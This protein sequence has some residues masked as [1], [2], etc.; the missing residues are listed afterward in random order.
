MVVEGLMGLA[1]TLFFVFIS[2]TGVFD[3][4]EALETKA[5]DVRARMAAH[6]DKNTQIELVVIGDEDLSE[7]GPFPWPRDILARGI[8]NL[9]LAGAKVIALNIPFSGPERDPGLTALRRLR[10]RYEVLGL[11]Q[12][13]SGLQFYEELSESERDLDND[14]KL[15]RSLKEAE[16][17]VLPVSFDESGKGSDEVRPDFM[18]AHAFKRIREGNRVG[19]PPI[20]RRFRQVKPI[21]HAFAEAAAGMGYNNLFPGPD[22][23]IRN[24][25]HAV[26]YSGG[27]YYPSFPLAIVKVFKGLRDEDMTLVLGDSIRLR[28]NPSTTLKV[29]LSDPVGTLI[30][31][32]QGPNKVFHYTPFT[33]VFKNQ[34]Q[35]GL[36]RDKIV[37]VG[38][39]AAHLGDRF[40]T[41]VSE[42]LPG[43]EIIANCVADILNED[44]FLRPSWTPLAEVA[45]IIL[46]GFFIT[47][48]LPRLR[49]GVGIGITL[50]LLAGYCVGGGV[51]FSISNIYLRVMPPLF[52]LIVGPM[53]V[54]STRLWMTGREERAQT[55]DGIYRER[56]ESRGWMG[57]AE[58]TVAL[59]PSTGMGPR[60][61]KGP[62]G[63]AAGRAALGR[64]ELLE[65]IGRGTMGVVYKGRDPKIG[66]TVAIK[67]VDLSEFDEEAL[68]E[69]KERFFREA[70]SVGLLSHP[71]IV[72]IYDCGEENHL[73]YM[74]M[75]YLDGE[76]L[77][78]YT[79]KEH[80]LPLRDTLEIISR[81]ADALEYA[82]RKNVVH[83]DIKPANVVRI[84][85]T[86]QVKVTD[87]GIA[88]IVTSSKTKT[89]VVL[90]T[91][92]YMSPE[93]VSGK[94]VD[95]RSDIFSLGVML[96]EMLTGQKP[97]TGED[98]TS[99]M[100]KIARERHP[101]PR[102]LNPRTP[103]VVEWIIDRALEKDLENRYQSAGQMASHLKKLVA[104]ID[105]YLARKQSAP[106]P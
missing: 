36:F 61:V 81:V 83:R 50:G 77:G 100:F 84:K 93:Q 3:F 43:I 67:T 15:S 5:F 44:F 72:S 63:D 73:A 94:K 18:A 52:L 24:Q 102:T 11:G 96:F 30:R 68:V 42:S 99:L 74:A 22:G 79:K 88:R 64:Y 41:P 57:E 65:E 9:S 51:L 60:A 55:Q 80:L 62:R 39:T 32:S 4:S 87:F 106:N 47:I 103:R 25:I 8:A 85:D 48:G 2:V 105:A 34:V 49:I 75:E 46:F 54:L 17:A 104:R 12:Q 16:N 53:L 76:A 23:H 91:P 27:L 21:V 78:R 26:G 86:H 6:R 56:G 31:W 20:P 14:A 89:G 71:N 28:I 13:G 69:I 66:R 29:P 90:G 59:G 10:E 70:E 45:L 40:I 33:K 1:V 58:P 38:F 35:T 37:I 97:F 82:H 92:Y 101:S 7:L 19:S 98:V 95:G